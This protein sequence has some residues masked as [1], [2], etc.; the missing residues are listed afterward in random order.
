MRNFQ[1]L[2]LYAQC[3]DIGF[4]LSHPPHAQGNTLIGNKELFSQ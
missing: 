3:V 4:K 1:H 2:G